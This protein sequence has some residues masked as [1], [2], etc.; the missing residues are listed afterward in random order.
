M[1]TKK[2]R[3]FCG[4]DQD[5]RHSAMSKTWNKPV[6][7]HGIGEDGE[8]V[9]VDSSQAASWALIEDWPEEDGE[10]LDKA[11]LVLAAVAQGKAKEDDGRTALIAAA[12]EAG[13]K[14]TA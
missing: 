4:G 6:I 5:E 12:L 8:D 7:L 3:I 14:I 13:V 10:A 1:E 11:L 2:G 9:V